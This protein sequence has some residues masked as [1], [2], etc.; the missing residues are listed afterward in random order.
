[1]FSKRASIYKA[2]DKKIGVKCALDRYVDINFEIQCNQNIQL[3]I[4]YF[5]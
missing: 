4:C 3:H 5:S 2:F 1:M